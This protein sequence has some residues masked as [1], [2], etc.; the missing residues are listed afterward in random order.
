[1]QKYLGSCPGDFIHTFERPLRSGIPLTLSQVHL[2]FPRKDERGLGKKTGEFSVSHVTPVAV[3]HL[4]GTP[5]SLTTLKRVFEL[6]T[7]VNESCKIIS[8][9]WHLHVVMSKVRA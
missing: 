7:V 9:T 2:Q 8:R 1:M 3:V 6:Q 4:C 5:S